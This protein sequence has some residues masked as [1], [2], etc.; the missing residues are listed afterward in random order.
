MSVK[1]RFDSWFEELVEKKAWVLHLQSDVIGQAK[2]YYDGLGTNMYV[3][4]ANGAPVQ[5]AVLE[6]ESGHALLAG[7][8]ERW[9]VLSKAE[10]QYFKTLQEGF[11]GLIVLSAKTAKDNG[12]ELETGLA[13]LVGILRAQLAALEAG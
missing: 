9:K 10:I 8:R 2:A 4:P 1:E 7:D 6:L 13:M 12:V 5:G 11:S 3:S